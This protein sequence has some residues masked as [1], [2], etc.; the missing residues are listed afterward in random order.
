MVRYLHIGNW[1][2]SADKSYRTLRAGLCIQE[3]E[4]RHFLIFGYFSS[5]TPSAMARVFQ[6][7]SCNY[8]MLLDMNA[9]EHTYLATYRKKDSQADIQYLIK[10]MSVLDKVVEGHLVP[11]F[12]GYA[13]NRDYFYLLRKENQ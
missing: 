7:Y 5:A 1:S 6:A 13:D 10:G 11:R 4:D 12:V 8:G 9:L 3:D 2:G